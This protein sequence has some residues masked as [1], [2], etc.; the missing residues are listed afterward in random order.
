MNLKKYGRL[1]CGKKS[2]PKIKHESLCNDYKAAGLKNVDISNKIKALQC[3]QIGTLYNNSFHE[4]KLILLYLVEKSL[5]SL[6]NFD[7]S[8]LI[9]SNVLFKNNKTQ[10]FPIF[11]EKLRAGKIRFSGA[12]KSV[13]LKASSGGRCAP[14]NFVHLATFRGTRVHLIVY[15]V[16]HQMNYLMEG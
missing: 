2:T 3:S 1:F 12:R 9:Q 15:L 8:K 10:F 14:K 7:I 11:Q 16:V 4:L 6:I 13:L 5:G